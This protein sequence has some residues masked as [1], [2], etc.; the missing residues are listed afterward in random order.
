M[1]II[2]PYA[3]MPDLF[4][5]LINDVFKRRSKK[6]INNQKEKAFSYL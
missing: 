4:Y 2:Y 1:S 5:F 6:G 3:A